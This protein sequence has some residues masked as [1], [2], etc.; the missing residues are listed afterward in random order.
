MTTGRI[1]QVTFLPDA[2][3]RMTVP[4]GAPFGASV[5]RPKRARQSFA[6]R[7]DACSLDGLRPRPHVHT[8]HSASE[9][10]GK[11]PWAKAAKRLS[12]RHAGNTETASRPP[13]TRKGTRQTG[14]IKT[15]NSV[16][17]VGST[18]YG[19]NPQG[20]SCAWG[21]TEADGLRAVRCTSTEPAD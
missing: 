3:A 13:R 8:Q 11:T 7:D 4:L 20:N 2:D 12:A 9:S 21:K 18:G 15:S 16:L 14:K 10:T 19:T 5:S 6:S 17:L 1:N